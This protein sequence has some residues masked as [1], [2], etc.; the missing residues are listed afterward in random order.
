VPPAAGAEAGRAAFV[1]GADSVLGSVTNDLASGE[2]VEALSLDDLRRRWGLD[3][4]ALI[5]DIEGGEWELINQ[6]AGVFVG[7]EQLFMELH[8]RQ[9]EDGS[10]ALLRRLTDVHGFVPVTRRG[11]VHYLMLRGTHGHA[12]G[13]L[14]ARQRAALVVA[15]L[16][17]AAVAAW[18]WRRRRP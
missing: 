18:R 16:G 1:A 15:A 14:A 2:P 13:G 9:C 17:V 4:Y 3:R 10:G 8:D 5:C 7:C 6:P 12:Q 11:P